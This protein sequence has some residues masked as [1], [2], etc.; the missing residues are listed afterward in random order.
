MGDR[1]VALE[2]VDGALDDVALL[3]ATSLTCLRRTC[4]AAAIRHFQREGNGQVSGF[5]L[6][7][8]DRHLI[9]YNDAHG[10]ELVRSTMTHEVSHVVLQH[11]PMLRVVGDKGCV[12]NSDVDQEAE[13]TEL[14][15][16]L[17][18]PAQVAKKAA[19]D[20]RPAEDL[21]CQF[22]T[23]AELARWRMNVSGGHQI[24]RRSRAR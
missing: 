4:P 6:L 19:I 14:G 16:E 5:A 3:V 23:S 20:Q 1:A 12:D 10:I 8:D 17:L 21:A 18:I 24:R 7:V 11:E 22:Q 9:A 15:G 2:L 13:A